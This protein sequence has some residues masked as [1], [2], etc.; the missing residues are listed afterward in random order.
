MRSVIRTILK[1]M[2]SQKV[3]D[4]ELAEIILDKMDEGF[5]EFDFERKA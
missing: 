3:L 2:M 1:K 4:L 5:S